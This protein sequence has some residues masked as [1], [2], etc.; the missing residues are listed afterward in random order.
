MAGMSIIIRPQQAHASP[1][2]TT[3]YTE[4]E[5]VAWGPF[6]GLT[7]DDMEALEIS[8]GGPQAGSLRPSGVR[9]ID[10]VY[11]SGP[12]P[13]LG[14]RVYCHYKVWSTGFRSGPV[15][16]WTYLDGRPYD[17]I[18]GSPTERIPSLVDESILGMAEGGWRRMVVPAAYGEKGLRKINPLKGGKRYTPPKAGYVIRPYE[19]AYFDVIM[20]QGGSSRCDDVLRPPGVPLTDAAKLKSRMCLQETPSPMD[21]GI[22]A[23]LRTL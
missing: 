17:W 6:A 16:D 3:K 7:A 23:T 4:P 21:V 18:L 14:Q 10:L 19:T 9:V 8:S 5:Q 2:F 15:A 11:G 12:Q 13:S 1:L 22:M 20:V